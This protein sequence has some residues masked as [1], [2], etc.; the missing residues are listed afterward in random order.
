MREYHY[1]CLGFYACSV[2]NSECFLFTV[3]DFK[4]GMI[5]S[6]ASFTS[7]WDG[8]ASFVPII[9][10]TKK[11]AGMGEPCLVCYNQSHRERKRPVL[12]NR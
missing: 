1:G 9:N 2:C 8:R 4:L 6:A 10:H 5:R 3:L 11:K 12:D 7:G